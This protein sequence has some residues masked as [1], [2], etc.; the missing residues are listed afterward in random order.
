M[1]THTLRDQLKAFAD[2]KN[3]PFLGD[4]SFFFYDWFCQD[5][6]LKRKALGLLPKVRKFVELMGID[7]DAHYVWFKNNCPLSGNLYDDFRISSVASGDN[8]WVVIPSSGY[9][10][11]HGVANVYNSDYGFETP[12]CSAESWSTLMRT[13]KEMKATK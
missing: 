12:F 1:R 5:K 3:D 4:S 7:L 6:S 13:L 8:K 10:K 2:N 9:K 11:D